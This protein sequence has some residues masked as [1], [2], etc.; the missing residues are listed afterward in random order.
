MTRL[1][2]EPRYPCP[3]CLGATMKKARLRDR[4]RS[5]LLDYCPRCGGMWFELG[6]VQRLRGHSQESFW[7]RVERRAAPF[8]MPCHECQALIDRN[9]DNCEACG[10]RNTIRCPHCAQDLKCEMH[11]GLRLDTCQRCK[12]VWFDNI[13]LEEIWKLSVKRGPA[14]GLDRSRLRGGDAGV[15]VDVLGHALFFA[16]DLFFYGAHASGMAL[17]AG[18]GAIGSVPGALAGAAE[19][20]AD[21]A[22]G[23]FDAIVDIISGLDF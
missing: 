22:S 20:V 5:L 4:E 10:R 13:E 6:E 18:A 2:L 12:G 3:V 14:T 8:K 1:T 15:G 21:A 16:P 23:V 9:A 7:Q 17:E 11:Q 19:G